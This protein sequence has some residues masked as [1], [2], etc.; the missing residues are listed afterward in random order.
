MLCYYFLSVLLFYLTDICQWCSLN[1]SRFLYFTSVDMLFGLG[2]S[3]ESVI[4]V[5]CNDVSITAVVEK[6]SSDLKRKT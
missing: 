4:S 5:S 3:V 1:G 6:C 2:L